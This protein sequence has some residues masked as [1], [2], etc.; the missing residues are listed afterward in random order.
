MCIRDSVEAYV[1]LEA[2][3]F[4]D[5]L[6]ETA[7]RLIVQY[8]PV[9]YREGTDL[10]ARE[11]VH[12]ASCMAGVAFTHAQ[13]GINHSI[14][15]ALGGHYRLPQ[16]CIRDRNGASPWAGRCASSPPTAASSPPAAPPVWRRT[17]A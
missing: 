8:L 13:L 12:N 3:D 9:A 17:A 6:A 7:V 1:A 11:H 14:A 15:H 16:M 4:T 5:A 10:E 2:S